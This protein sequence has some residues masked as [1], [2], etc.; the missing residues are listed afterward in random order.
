MR[1]VVVCGAALVRDEARVALDGVPDEPGVSHRIFAAI[2][3]RNIVVDMIA[4]NVGSDGR[5]AI[6]FTVPGNELPATL[7]VLRPLAAELGATR[8]ARRGSQQGVDRRHRHADAHRRR[9]DACSPPWPP[10]AINMKMITTG[11]IKISVLV[12][13][14]D[15]MRALRAVHQAFRPATSRVPAP[16]SR[17]PAG[18]SPFQPRP[19]ATR[20]ASP[21]AT[22]PC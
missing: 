4:Q 2:A 16:V 17:P 14:A 12:D 6:G 9:R 21:A 11:D 7:A 19:A 5:A 22:W 13:R 18:D 20:R 10:R 1:E 8:R 3:D 15:G